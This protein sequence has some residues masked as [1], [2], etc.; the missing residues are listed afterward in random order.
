MIYT[1]R[2]LLI[3]SGIA[4]ML[5]VHSAD[6]KLWAA[7]LLSLPLAVW[8]LGKKNVHPVLPWLVAL[9]WLTITSDLVLAEFTGLSLTQNDASLFRQDAILFSLAAMLALAFGMRAGTFL[10]RKQFVAAFRHAGRF[11]AAVPQR[12]DH[13]RA[14]QA[15]FVSLVFAAIADQAAW[16]VPPLTQLIL[17]MTLVKFACIYLVAVKYFEEGQGGKWLLLIAVLE[18][19]SG[20]ISYFS[21]Y[22]EVVFVII[23]AMAAGRRKLP[24]FQLGLGLCGVALVVWMSLVWSVIK[25]PFRAISAG[26]TTEEKIDWMLDNY[27]RPDFDYSQAFT[28]LSQRVGYTK[29]FAAVLE[30]QDQGPLD[31]YDFYQGAIMHILTPR[32][33][34]PDKPALD[35]SKITVDVLGININEGTSIGLGYTTQAYIDFGFPGMLIPIGL[36]GMMLGWTA[37]YFLSRPVPAA[38]SGAFATALMFEAFQYAADIDK[39]FGGFVTQF[40]VM[41][42]LLRFGYPIIAPWRAGAPGRSGMLPEPA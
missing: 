36:I 34:F 16:Y 17:A 29:F 9:F 35:D 7:S 37:Q 22:K 14:V 32:L 4:L 25:G 41:A 40:I 31:S 12:N 11:H 21:S 15:Y 30:R 8:I 13:R 23:I 6:L 19:A 27:T 3:G 2:T 33:F 10:G 18:I 24:L 28:N 26:M 38:L 39:A 42:F 5:L 20:A 1:P